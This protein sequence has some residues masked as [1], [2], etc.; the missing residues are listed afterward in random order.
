MAKQVKE[1]TAPAVAG[2]VCKYNV[3]LGC[4]EQFGCALCGW[5]PYSE[6]RKR[7]IAAALADRNAKLRS[8]EIHL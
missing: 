3:G 8:G 5:N 6:I 4:S 1:K 2:E 7:R